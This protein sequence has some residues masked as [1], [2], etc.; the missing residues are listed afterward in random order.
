MASLILPDPRWIWPNLARDGQNLAG[1]YQNLDEAAP[2]RLRP[3]WL[4]SD[5][6]QSWPTLVETSPDTHRNWL[7]LAETALEIGDDTLYLV[8]CA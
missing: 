3:A 4:V 6:C 8:A 1:N 7:A 5:I 2:D